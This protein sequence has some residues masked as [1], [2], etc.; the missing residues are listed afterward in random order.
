MP[1]NETTLPARVAEFYSQL[2][3][4]AKDL[5]DISD[6]LGKCIAEIDV[7]LRKLNLGVVVWVPIREDSGVP[8]ASWY[9]SEDIGYA[10]VG[11]NWGI[12]L[13]KVTGDYQGGDEAEE[14]ESWLFNDAP[15]SLRISAIGKI[16]TLLEKLSKEAVKTTNDIRARLTDAKA[17][18]D[19]VKT[20]AN[21]TRV[22]IARFPLRVPPP[23][24]GGTGQSSGDPS[25]DSVRTEVSAALANAGHESASQLLRS[26]TWVKE[27]D[28]L[29]IEACIG[30]KMLALT[31]NASAEKII[32]QELQKLGGPTRFLLVPGGNVE[33]G[34]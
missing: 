26:A 20:A 6:E 19:A 2:S 4:A 21:Q 17:V 32:L 7:A 16:P 18:A 24:G 31:V 30:K 15:R 9:W 11:A 27:G 1:S 23:S 14:V 28:C 25:L 12:C 22:P 3:T 33:V 8:E 10:K 13:R 29:R 34:K 5:N